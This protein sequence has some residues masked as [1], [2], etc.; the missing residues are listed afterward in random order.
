[1]NRLARL[2]GG[3]GRLLT[4]AWIETEKA[5]FAAQL[6]AGRLLTEAWIETSEQ[7]RED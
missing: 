1:M 7:A 4:E 6:I 3:R 5:L 2:G